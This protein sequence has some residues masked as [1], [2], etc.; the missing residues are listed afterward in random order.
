M[1]Y[2]AIHLRPGCPARHFERNQLTP[3]L[4]SLSPLAQDYPSDLHINTGIGPPP[5]FRATSPYHGLDRLVPGPTAMTPGTF[6]PR[7]SFLAEMWTCR[8]RYGSGLLTLNL[9]ITVDSPP[10]FSTRMARLWS[11]LLV[12]LPHESFLR[13]G[14][15]LSSRTGL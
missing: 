15:F 3:V 9:A 4:I 1:L 13:R 6:I 14:S 5:R 12:L 8:F 7:P 11:P 2:T 10:R